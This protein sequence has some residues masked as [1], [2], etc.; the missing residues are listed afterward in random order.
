MFNIITYYVKHNIIM[1]R[2]TG[3]RLLS[4]W[5]NAVWVLFRNSRECQP[6]CLSLPFFY[7]S[8]S[9]LL[10]RTYTWLSSPR[11]H[12]SFKIDC[13]GRKWLSLW[14][15]SVLCTTSYF[16]IPIIDLV[17]SLPYQYI[18]IYFNTSIFIWQNKQ[19]RDITIMLEL[20]F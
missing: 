9:P 6:Q 2:M 5:W 19:K 8:T 11:L 1:S 14:F 10:T 7:P 17:Q 16:S 18:M 20:P 3:I 12:R 15:S 13:L 4:V